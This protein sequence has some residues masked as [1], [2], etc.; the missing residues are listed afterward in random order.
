MNTG[1]RNSALL[2]PVFPWLG[3]AKLDE[4]QVRDIRL[5]TMPVRELAREYSVDRQTIKK[6]QDGKSYKQFEWTDGERS[7]T[8]HR[9]PGNTRSQFGPKEIAE[10][11]ES[12]MTHAAIATKYGVSRALVSRRLKEYKGDTT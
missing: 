9:T 10:A 2:R 8:H 5:S 12:G 11:A 6:I 1:P 4:S 3:R 7:T